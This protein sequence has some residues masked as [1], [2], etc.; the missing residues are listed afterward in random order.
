MPIAPLLWPS[1]STPASEVVALKD[2]YAHLVGLEYSAQAWEAALFLY[3]TG[4][5]PP[6][7][8]PRSVGRSWCFIAGRECVM[9]LFHL[10][11]RLGKIR[12]VFLRKCPSIQQLIDAKKLRAASKRLDEYFPDIE[13]LRHAVAHTGENEAHPETHAPGGRFALTSLT[14]D[15]RFALPYEGTLRQIAVSEASLQK[16]HIVLDEYFA[17]FNPAAELLRTQGHVD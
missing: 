14:E 17:A 9:E 16:I 12:S 7:A 3:Q 8:I 13:L 5:M 11:A 15:G 4:R 2:L 10:R 1:I 6:P